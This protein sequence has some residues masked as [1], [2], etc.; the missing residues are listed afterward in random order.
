MKTL[1][2]GNEALALGAFHAGVR[3]ATAY[4][5]TPSTE[6]LAYLSQFNDVY[7]EWSTNEQVAVEVAL[8][9][10]YGGVR[11][12]AIMKHVGLNVASDAF[13]A[14]AT[15]GIKSGL[16]IVSADDPGIH[17]S[18][19]E[20]DNR[21][22]APLAKVPLLEPSDSQEAYDLMFAAYE[23]SEKYDVPVLVRSTTRIS[24]SKTIV[25]THE[26]LDKKTLNARFEYDPTKFIMLPSFARLR[27]PIIEERILDLSKF[28]DNNKANYILEGN[29]DFGIISSG[30]AYQYAR[31]ILPQASF[32]KLTMTYPLPKKLIKRFARSVK[33]LIVIEELDP[34]LEESIRSMGLIVEGKNTIPLIG[35]LNPDI[36]RASAESAGL[37]SSKVKLKT[38]IPS[39]PERPPLLCPGCPHTGFFFSLSLLGFRSSTSTKIKRRPRFVITGDIGCY[40][41][42]AYEPF[43][44]L[45]TC[46]CMGASIGQAIGLEK[47]GV[48]ESIIAVIGDSTF[49]HSGITG[50]LDAVYNQSKI[51]IVILDNMTTAMTGHQGHPG[52]GI[53]PQG[54]LRNRV[55]IEDLVRGTGIADVRVID[56]FNLKTIRY[57]LREATNNSQ[58][59]V[60]IVRGDCPTLIPKKGEPRSIIQ[61]KCDDCGLC[62]NIGCPALEKTDKGVI[63]NQSLCIGQN[64]NL[65]LQFC[66]K[67][68]VASYPDAG[69]QEP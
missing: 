41:L 23:I 34:F 65:C 13:M 52:T 19:N 11:A 40:T 16:V 26:P 30:I 43:L 38:K 29:S 10:S 36:V 61:E 42:A 4:P 35:E 20:Q 32:L 44:A 54:Q 8:G 62:L 39:L 66:P 63:I 24:H 64:C 28:N 51:T 53:S 67:K 37:I 56:A 14:A 9:A 33:R 25:K 1:L 45:D 48:D 18:Q 47:A 12:L 69:D 46:G 21:H 68:A 22:F 55:I 50:L 27:R 7:S 2:S 17:S 31:E 59:T 60:L 57:H 6:I 5:G 3:V 49:M 15:T 58:L